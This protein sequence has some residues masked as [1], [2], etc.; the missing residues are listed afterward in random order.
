M[1]TAATDDANITLDVFAQAGGEVRRGCGG[2]VVLLQGA[3]GGQHIIICYAREL[4]VVR[5]RAA[6]GL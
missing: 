5:R 6:W 2:G 1:R 3:V 4:R